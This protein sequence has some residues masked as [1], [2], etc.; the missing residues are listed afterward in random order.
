MAR[1]PRTSSRR[2]RP[3]YRPVGQKRSGFLKTDHGG[4]RNQLEKKPRLLDRV[5]HNHRRIVA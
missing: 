2:E 4:R 3:T 1:A 5:R